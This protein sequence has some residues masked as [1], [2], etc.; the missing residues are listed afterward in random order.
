M[1]LNP[2]G[3]KSQA[4]NKESVRAVKNQERLSKTINSI[5]MLAIITL[6]G[7]IYPT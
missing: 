4:F 1:V 3:S 5:V 2:Y 7:E 6:S